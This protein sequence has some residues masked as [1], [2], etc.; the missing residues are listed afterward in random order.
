M[1]HSLNAYATSSVLIARQQR[2][3][4]IG[5]KAPP[6]TVLIWATHAMGMIAAFGRFDL[7]ALHAATP[8]AFVSLFLMMAEELVTPEVIKP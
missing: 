8:R 5:C 2:Y 3:S 1:P 6:S 4:L 7:A